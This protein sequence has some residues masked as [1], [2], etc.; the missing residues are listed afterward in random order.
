MTDWSAKLK[1][2]ST[3]VWE[4]PLD[5]FFSFLD[6]EIGSDCTE[7]RR[8]TDAEW[9]QLKGIMATRKDLIFELSNACMGFGC[10]I[11]VGRMMY[12][13]YPGLLNE[14]EWL[15]C[16]T[17]NH[18]PLSVCALRDPGEHGYNCNDRTFFKDGWRAFS[19]FTHTSENAKH[20]KDFK[21]EAP[22]PEGHYDY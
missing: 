14:I 20:L 19:P 5:E 2:L 8:L 7:K 11:S 16:V 13:P 21:R 12:A 4:G 6:N 22:R 18:L 9:E 3:E 1:G 10:A 15:L 17:K